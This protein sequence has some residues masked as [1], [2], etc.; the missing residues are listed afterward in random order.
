MS[1][2]ERSCAAFRRWRAA[3]DGRAGPSVA[4][5]TGELRI[6]PGK[7]KPMVQRRRGRGWGTL[8][9]GYAPRRA[10]LGSK[11]VEDRN[12]LGYGGYCLLRRSGRR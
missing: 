7:A 2:R 6:T 8:R 9:Q 3:P 12:G 5:I 1:F 11:D 10:K 4:P